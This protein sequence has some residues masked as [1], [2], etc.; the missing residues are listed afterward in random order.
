MCNYTR[1]VNVGKGQTSQTIGLGDA[2]TPV[3]YLYA[4]CKDVAV[5]GTLPNGLNFKKSNSVWTLSGT[6]TAM[7]T[8]T[9]KVKSSGDVSL[10]SIEQTVTVKVEQPTGIA[11]LPV[12]GFA[13]VQAY[14]LNRRLVFE[15]NMEAE[16]LALRMTELLGKGIFILNV[17][18]EGRTY[19]Q[20]IVN[21]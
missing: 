13:K 15:E 4:H 11:N 16:G 6:P 20:K 5:E 7:G 17:T 9:F 8:Y 10:K 12:R 18:T 21:L 1:F 3:S 14:D 2:I 19:H